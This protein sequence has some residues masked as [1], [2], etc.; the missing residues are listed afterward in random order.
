[1]PGEPRSSDLA[2]LNVLVGAW[3]TEATHPST[4]ST[5]V[6]GR[7]TFEWLE[8]ERFLIERSWA[9]HPDFPNALWV[10]GDADKALSAHYFD[11]RGVQRVYGVQMRDGELRMWRDAPGFAQRFTG[12]LRDGGRTLVGLWELSRDGSTWD[13]DLAITFRRA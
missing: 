11:S 3:T 6:P 9:E 7:A 8:G 1:M 12:T 2:A 4:G 10:I 13:D 5:V